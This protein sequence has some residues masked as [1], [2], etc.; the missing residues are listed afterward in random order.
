MILWR[1][2]KQQLIRLLDLTLLGCILVS[3]H[4][5]CVILLT[6]TVLGNTIVKR[7]IF[8]LSPKCSTNRRGISILPNRN[9][10]SITSLCVQVTAA[11]VHVRVRLSVSRMQNGPSRSGGL[12]RPRGIW[13]DTQPPP[14]GGTDET[15]QTCAPNPLSEASFLRFLNREGPKDGPVF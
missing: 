5:L 7:F 14:F 6:F 1:E 12:K 8:R 4:I 13:P 10:P 11:V 3:F 15:C 2:S 9:R